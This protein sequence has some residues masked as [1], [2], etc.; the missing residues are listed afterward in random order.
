[1]KI[2]RFPTKRKK[3]TPFDRLD[4]EVN[5]RIKPVAVV[6][7]KP[8]DIFTPRAIKVFKT[9]APKKQK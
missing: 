9:Y 2:R 8:E 1:M 7:C 5:N 4:P 3:H 6:R